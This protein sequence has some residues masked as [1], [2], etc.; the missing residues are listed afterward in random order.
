MESPP[1]LEFSLCP[2]ATRGSHCFLRA[3]LPFFPAAGQNVII[4]LKLHAVVIMTGS[5]YFKARL[6][7]AAANDRQQPKWTASDDGCL[8]MARLCEW[9]HGR[10]GG[11]RRRRALLVEYVG[12]GEPELA[13]AVLHSMYGW[14]SLSAALRASPLKLLRTLQLA[15][16]F[17][18]G[19]CVA[20]CLE[21]LNKL[22]LEAWAVDAIAH[23]LELPE[24]T[25]LAGSGDPSSGQRRGGSSPSASGQR[26]M[27]IGSDGPSSERLM[28]VGSDGPSSEQ[29]GGSKRLMVLQRRAR[30]EIAERYGDLSRVAKAGP[31][32]QLYRQFLGLPLSAVCAVLSSGADCGLEASAKQRGRLAAAWLQGERG[33][34]C[35]PMQRSVLEGAAGSTPT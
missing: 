11:G 12:E 8:I 3:C 2:S 17:Q 10:L 1:R 16:R 27:R 30:K 13:R 33:Q 9:L 26:L 29:L 32:G 19:R 18:V 23:L 35:D 31:D 5:P 34:R 21:A 4:R 6:N 25:L 7:A 24:E 22:P 14:K 20:L 28:R 15:A